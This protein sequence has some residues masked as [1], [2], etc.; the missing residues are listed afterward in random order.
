MIG[1]GYNFALHLKDH[2]YRVTQ[3][4]VGAAPRDREK[5]ANAKAEYYWGLR[6]RFE[7]GAVVGITDET[8]IGQLAGIRYAPNSR[9]Q[10]T[11]ESK[12]A[13]RKRGVHSPDRAEA[14]ML[15]FAVTGRGMGFG[16][17][18]S[19]PDFQAA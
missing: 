7:A 13:A 9:G 14:V 15:A 12:E 3:I 2:G 16:W 4:N 8:T 5:Y 1:I 11:I 10:T 6:E 18:T 19:D 17:I